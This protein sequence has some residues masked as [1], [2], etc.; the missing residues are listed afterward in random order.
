M[1]L[2]T[3]NFL[4]YRIKRIEKTLDYSALQDTLYLHECRL[5]YKELI[6]LKR[7]LAKIKRIYRKELKNEKTEIHS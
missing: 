5:M 2:E 7:T 4:K 3:I 1:D 6:V